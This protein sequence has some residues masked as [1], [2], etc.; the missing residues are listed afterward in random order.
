[1]K[2]KDF[3]TVAKSFFDEHGTVRHHIQSF[4][5]FLEDGMQRVVDEVGGIFPTILPEG[6]TDY[7][8]HFGKIR[9]GQPI[10]KEADGSINLL[11]PMEARLRELTYASPI[12]LE[13]IPEKDGIMSEPQNAIIGNIPIMVKTKVCSLR[14]LTEEELV[15]SHEDPNDPGGYF[16]INGTERA[17]IAIE[18][19]VPNIPLLEKKT[20]GP[21]TE[22]ARLFSEAPGFR[23]P[24]LFERLKDGTIRT[25]FARV[26]RIPLVSLIIALGIESDKEIMELISDKEEFA[27]DVLI[28][29]DA[30]GEAR[31][32]EDALDWIGRKMKIGQGREY[33]VQRVR[34][35]IDTYL[36]PHIG[37]TKEHRIEKAHYIGRLAEKLMKLSQG[38][39]EEDDKDHYANKR[40]KLSGELMEQIFR[41]AFKALVNDMKYSFERITKRGREP[42]IVTIVRSQ[43]LTSRLDSALATGYWVGG[44][45]GVS[46]H[47]QRLNHMDTISH[48]RRVLSPLT[49]SQPHFEARELHPT[50]W[51]KLC[52]SETPEGQNIGLRKN[53]A[54]FAK[55]T[56]GMDPEEVKK[57]LEESGVKA[58]WGGN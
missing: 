1:L 58:P 52:A 17:L 55:A 35:L 40:L 7:K 28:N 5:T 2:V 46:Q 4:D 12:H 44:R 26:N 53:L 3:G 30:T 57:V 11:Y 22:I 14:G 32:E 25:S 39:V 23:V 24:H 37:N 33:R 54:L 6:C 43:L 51:G 8:I 47:L 10:I 16:I 29:L 42:P 15:E 38:M 31:N 20:S 13:L 45:S 50:H 18:D 27:E 41:A 34:E 9:V 36:L 48:L 49:T 56:H 21:S 19:L